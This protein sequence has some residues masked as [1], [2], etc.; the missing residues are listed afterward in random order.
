MSACRGNW[1]GGEGVAEITFPSVNSTEECGWRLLT[2][3]A[4]TEICF[5][6]PQGDMLKVLHRA[7]LLL[8]LKEGLSW[9]GVGCHTHVY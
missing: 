5:A 7:L 2:Q 4:Q 3:A 6:L 1:K 9:C 8:N